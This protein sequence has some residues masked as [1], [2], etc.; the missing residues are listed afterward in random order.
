M[1]RGACVGLLGCDDAQGTAN[2]RDFGAEGD[3]TTDDTAAFTTNQIIDGFPSSSGLRAA[4]NKPSTR[5]Y[6]VSSATISPCGTI[7]IRMVSFNQILFLMHCYLA[8]QLV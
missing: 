5:R 3:G 1:V 7:S 8:I 6:F 4:M 2:V